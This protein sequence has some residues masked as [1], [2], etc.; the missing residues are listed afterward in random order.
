MSDT[1]LVWIAVFVSTIGGFLFG[2]IMQS[3]IK[4][5]EAVRRGH[6]TWSVGVDGGSSFEWKEACK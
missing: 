2:T 6:A 4:H 5:R 1:K 3:E